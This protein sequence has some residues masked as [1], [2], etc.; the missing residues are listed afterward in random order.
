MF[1]TSST[2][3]RQEMER[4]FHWGTFGR[5]RHA[6]VAGNW[7]HG[8]PCKARYLDTNNT[9]MGKGK[10]WTE[11]IGFT[12]VHQVI[13]CPKMRLIS[14]YRMKP[15][16]PVRIFNNHASTGFE[17]IHRPGLL[18][19]CKTKY[20]KLPWQVIVK[21]VFSVRWEVQA[22]TRDRGIKFH[23]IGLLQVESTTNSWL[24]ISDFRSKPRWNEFSGL[25][26]H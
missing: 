13:L 19:H 18:K 4:G 23:S 22:Q 10:T 8:Q 21:L 1:L 7:L 16:Q 25:G 12:W 11:L 24:I 3:W 2:T 6:R 14:S 9:D 15:H 20:Q 5:C 17:H 26:L